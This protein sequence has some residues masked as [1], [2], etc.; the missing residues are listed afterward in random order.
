MREGKFLFRSMGLVLSGLFA[1]ALA[2]A[3][4]AQPAMCGTIRAEI[5]NLGRD[6]IGGNPREAARLRTEIANIRNAIRAN[7]CDDRGFFGFGGPPP[8][9]APLRAQAQQMEA[10]LRQAEPMDANAPRRA[11]LLAAYQRYGCDTSQPQQRGVIYAQPQTGLLE[12]LF[13]SSATLDQRRETLTTLEAD[14]DQELQEK[15]RL[16]GRTPVCVRTCDGFFFPVNFE[17]LTARDEHGRVCE[18]LCPAAETVVMYMRLGAEIETAATRDGQAYTAFPF[19]LKFRES[20]NNACF[21]RPPGYTVAQ[22][23]RGQEDYVE[24]RKGDLVV[25]REQAEAMSRPR[26]LRG[27]APQRP[28]ANARGQQRNQPAPAPARAAEEP[29][30]VP[31]SAIPTAGTAS[32]G[33]GP[34]LGNERVLNGAQGQTQEVVGADGVRR[35]VRVVAPAPN[36]PEPQPA[37]R[38]AARPSTPAPARAP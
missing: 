7:N 3:A 23:A 10:R 14:L 31:E 13:G 37:P 9:C 26:E 17:G 6:T 2:G 25:T 12:R 29:A 4:H 15:A 32:A 27:P 21:C 33:I 1:L 36:A 8:V 20:R 30:P 28:Q 11:Q 24:A 22:L 18:A 16:G 5:A 34:R 35:Q 38:G 19:A